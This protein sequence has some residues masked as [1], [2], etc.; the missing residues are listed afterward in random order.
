MTRL[1]RYF[2]SLP[3]AVLVFVCL[4]LLLR[5]EIREDPP[6]LAVTEPGLWTIEN[7]G[8]IL[9]VKIRTRCHGMPVGAL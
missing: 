3:Y 7:S 6:K 4:S 8:T 5:A 9:I 2:H 1:Q